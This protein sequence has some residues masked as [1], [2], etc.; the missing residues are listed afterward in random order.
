[1][2]KYILGIV[3]I[4]V[5]SLLGVVYFLINLDPNGLNGKELLIFYINLFLCLAGLI[6]LVGILFRRTRSRFFFNWKMFKPAFRQGMILSGLL[7]LIL[8][9]LSKRI[10]N[11]PLSLLFLASGILFEFLIAYREKRKIYAAGVSKN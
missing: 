1:M 4:T 7:V 3:L 2:L 10:F 11:G 6:T 8:F 9:F 5:L